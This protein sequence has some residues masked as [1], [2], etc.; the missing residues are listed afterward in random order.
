MI[1][2]TASRTC[3]RSDHILGLFMLK[4]HWLL[5]MCFGAYQRSKATLPVSKE[6]CTY[7]EEAILMTRSTLMR[8]EERIH[9]KISE[10]AA[11]LKESLVF[12][13]QSKIEIILMMLCEV[14]KRT[15]K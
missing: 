5:I 8:S 4:F 10:L 6:K 3:L 11:R 14:T 7:F 12:S 13:I 15:E 2:Y 9:A 1:P